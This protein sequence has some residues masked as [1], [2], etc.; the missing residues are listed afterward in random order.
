MMEIR[1]PRESLRVWWK[2]CGTRND[3]SAGSRP[4]RQA[5]GDILI[6]DGVFSHPETKLS[7]K[8]LPASPSVTSAASV[9]CFPPKRVRPEA[10]VT[11]KAPSGVQRWIPLC[12]LR[13]LCAMLSPKRVFPARTSSYPPKHVPPF[14]APSLC[15]L[16]GLCAML[17]PK[18]VFPAQKPR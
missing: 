11:T 3:S 10:K 6:Q 12:D 17:F 4:G 18:R 2:K 13:G 14:N 16:R 1:R 15:D 8:R 9:R 7:P 5:R